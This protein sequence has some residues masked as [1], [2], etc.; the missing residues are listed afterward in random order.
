MKSKFKNK[1]VFYNDKS[2]H[3]K[4]K[5]PYW[6]VLSVEKEYHPKLSGGDRYIV[7][8]MDIRG[9]HDTLKTT[10][11]Y[12]YKNMEILNPSKVEHLLYDFIRGVFNGVYA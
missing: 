11:H 8:Y 10:Q 5:S 7:S 6:F 9:N 2:Y 1:I 4:N 12:L 3:N